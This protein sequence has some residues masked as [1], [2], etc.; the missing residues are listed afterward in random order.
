MLVASFNGLYV[1]SMITSFIYECTFIFLLSISPCSADLLTFNEDSSNWALSARPFTLETFFAYTP[2]KGHV[3]IL[4]IMILFVLTSWHILNSF[5][6]PLNWQSIILELN[7]SYWT[8]WLFEWKIVNFTSS[9]KS[10]S[11]KQT[12]LS[13]KLFE[14]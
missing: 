4:G 14:M 2:S 10:H 1:C 5:T 7:W 8:Y 12:K 6:V 3:N 11:A 13:W 9:L